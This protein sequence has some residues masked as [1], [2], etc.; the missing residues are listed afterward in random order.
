VTAEAAPRG[1]RAIGTTFA[2]PSGAHPLPDRPRIRPLPGSPPDLL[3]LTLIARRSAPV[4][5]LTPEP[6]A[7]MVVEHA[8]GPVVFGGD[9][10]SMPGPDAPLLSIPVVARQAIPSGAIRPPPMADAPPPARRGP[11]V[12][13]TGSYA[14][15]YGDGCAVVPIAALE[16]IVAA[17]DMAMPR[18]A[19]DLPGAI[20][21]VEIGGGPA[22]LLDPGW[23]TGKLAAAAPSRLAAVF[24]QEG[25][26]LAMPV[27][28]A[29]PGA[30]GPDLGAR[31]GGTPEGR[32]LLAA[33]PPVGATPPPQP[34][35]RLRPL[36][37]CEAGET[38]FALDLADVATVLAPARPTPVP[39]GTASALRGV[40][41]HR[42][43]VLPVVDLAARL[44]PALDTDA[45]SAAPLLRLALP[46][47]LAVP[48]GRVLGLHPV[49][50][51]RVATVADD[52]LVTGHVVLD[53]RTVPICQADALAAPRAG[54]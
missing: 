34:V 7:W 9:G 15:V 30:E 5:R 22:L 3:G 45:L 47:P 28:R 6:A 46:R 24:R 23:C 48:V 29:R 4:W 42:G 16:G 8:G 53:G 2:V 52:A 14:L 33:A 12:T 51:R 37:L 44:A 43:E 32:A 18:P 10:W 17:P 27:D 38:R 20:G 49:P 40:V 26:R 36:L 54:A 11:P 21:Q 19:I 50:A 31:L 25:R 39:R 13:A 1:L 35:D 41:S